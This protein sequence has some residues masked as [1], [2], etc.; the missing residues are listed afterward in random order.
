MHSFNV[1]ILNFS[2][3]I[4][5]EHGGRNRSRDD[6]GGRRRLVAHDGMSYKNTAL[7]TIRSLYV[8]AFVSSTKSFDISSSRS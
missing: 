1:K 5:I 7:P 2:S 3:Q 8:L 4:P 6:W